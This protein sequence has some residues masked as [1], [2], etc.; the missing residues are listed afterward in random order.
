MQIKTTLRSKTKTFNMKEYSILSNAFSASSVMI[1][2]FFF[3]EFV[4][5]VDYADGF[6][7]SKPYCIPGLKYT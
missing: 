4:Y 3:F 6:P 2:C 1:M 5:V 7:Y